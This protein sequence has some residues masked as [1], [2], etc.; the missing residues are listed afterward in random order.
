MWGIYTFTSIYGPKGFDMICY[1]LWTEKAEK[2]GRPTAPLDGLEDG[3]RPRELEDVGKLGQGSPG[4][5]ATQLHAVSHLF[6]LFLRLFKPSSRLKLSF[7]VLNMCA[8]VALLLSCHILV[9]KLCR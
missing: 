3:I 4:D 7:A 6:L 8:L 5:L 9:V 1:F 2:Y